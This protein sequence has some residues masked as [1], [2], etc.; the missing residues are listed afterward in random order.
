MNSSISI[1]LNAFKS[2][3]KLVGGGAIGNIYVF[4]ILAI[5]LTSTGITI[6]CPLALL[7]IGITISGSDLFARTERLV[8]KG[9]TLFSSLLLKL[10]WI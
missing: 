4:L 6:C 7:S 2:F 8:F 10:P 1:K 5:F 9:F 3:I